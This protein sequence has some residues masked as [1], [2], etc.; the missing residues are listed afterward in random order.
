MPTPSL[1]P[2][3]RNRAPKPWLFDLCYFLP[4]R[5]ALSG[6]TGG[7]RSG[8]GFLPAPR[9]STVLPSTE[10]EAGGPCGCNDGG[11]RANPLP[12]FSFHLVFS[13]RVPVRAATGKATAAARNDLRS[14]R[15]A[16]RAGALWVV[17]RCSVRRAVVTEL[18][19]AR[20][21]RSACGRQRLARTQIQTGG[22]RIWWAGVRIRPVGHLRR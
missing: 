6:D 21:R 14:T 12:T 7:S 20:W 18:R 1:P 10:H 9:L 15:R 3:A 19:P 13:D 8:A 22:R 2:A 11:D 16:R 17:P 4:P 5:R